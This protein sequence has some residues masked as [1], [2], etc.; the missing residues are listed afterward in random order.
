MTPIR[1]RLLSRRRVAGAGLDGA[2]V[3]GVER[4]QVFALPPLRWEVT[5]H[6]VISRGCPGGVMTQA[7]APAGVQ[8][9][10]QY[11]PRLGGVGGSLFHG[12]CLS[13]SRAGQGA[14]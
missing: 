9:P 5:K 6:R 7:Q 13:K 4:R 14:G 8:A 11:G 3:V 12:Q 1:S 10:V 2:A